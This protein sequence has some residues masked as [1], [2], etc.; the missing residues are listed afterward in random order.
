MSEVDLRQILITEPILE[1]VKKIS[2]NPQFEF[3]KFKKQRGEQ[4]FPLNRLDLLESTDP[5]TLRAIPGR[6][7]KIDGSIKQ[8]YEIIDGRHRV[9]YAIATKKNTINAMVKN[10]A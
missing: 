4:G 6:G 5:I 2:G 9:A 10:S 1:A 7:T 3:H 8:V